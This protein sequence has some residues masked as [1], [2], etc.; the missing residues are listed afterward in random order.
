M[1]CMELQRAGGLLGPQL[2]T[3]PS[4]SARQRVA[5]ASDAGELRRGPADLQGAQ[6]GDD[7][8]LSPA[9]ALHRYAPQQ[10]AAA[11]HRRA[12]GGWQPTLFMDI[13]TQLVVSA[14]QLVNVAASWRGDAP[15]G[16]RIQPALIALG[17]L[18]IV[19]AMY[20][21]LRQYWRHR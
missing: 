2:V 15:P 12:S 14:A 13:S 20:F 1:C 9:A 10:W 11:T 16:T 3:N 6:D 8:G 18:L 4:Q 5:A 21:W 7:T 17:N 19:A